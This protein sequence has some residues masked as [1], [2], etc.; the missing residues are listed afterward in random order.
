MT[1]VP[2]ARQRLLHEDGLPLQ[3]LQFGD[4]AVDERDQFRWFHGLPFGVRGERPHLLVLPP[5][6]PAIKASPP[7]FDQRGLFGGAVVPLAGILSRNPRHWDRRRPEMIYT[8]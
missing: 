5:D 6:P 8:P 3:R 2:V 4:V 7:S 1:H